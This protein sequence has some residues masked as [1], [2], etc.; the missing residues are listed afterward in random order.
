MTYG[1]NEKCTKF[2]L[3]NQQGQNH[4]EDLGI[5]GMIISKWIISK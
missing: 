4:S 3:E 1:K 5:G 2:W